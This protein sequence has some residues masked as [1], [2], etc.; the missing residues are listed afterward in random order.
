MPT[1]PLFPLK[2]ILKRHYEQRGRSW[3]AL[4]LA[5]E[6]ANAS[7]PDRPKH[8][9]DR[10]KLERLCG[11]DYARVNLSIAE[12]EALDTYLLRF[13]EGLAE[14]PI[15]ARQDDLLDA[16]LE[17]SQLHFFV[18]AKPHPEIGVEAISRW[19]LRAITRV[20]RSKIAELDVKIWDITDMEDW[21]GVAQHARHYAQIAIGSPIANVSSEILLADMLHVTP[22]QSCSVDTLPFFLVRRDADQTGI[23]AFVYAREDVTFAG[24]RRDQR[25]L[26]IAGEVFI[27]ESINE[28]YAL[29][30]A[31]WLPHARQ[32]RLV[33]SGVSGPGTYGLAKAL[34]KGL[35]SVDLRQIDPDTRLPILAVVFRVSFER[36]EEQVKTI[37]RD[38]RRR[39]RP[40][41]QRPMYLFRYKEGRWL[42]ETI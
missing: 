37:G 42:S 25:A 22:F 26:V 4:A 36:R 23:S 7:R 21:P 32:I 5:I 2:D 40:E 31:Q 38:P 11:D 12:L 33:L 15:F 14:H 30:V 16:I 8:K 24:V 34:Q 41:I 10:R 17:S 18:A 3:N 39:I 28:D 6:A 20:I 35:V 29:L 19:D 13:N 27:P 9:I 1:V